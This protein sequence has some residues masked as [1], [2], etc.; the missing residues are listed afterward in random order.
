[1]VRFQPNRCLEVLR[2]E[3]SQIPL[4]HGVSREALKIKVGAAVEPTGA[5][6][7]WDFDG[8]LNE[9]SDLYCER[10]GVLFYRN[11]R[12]VVQKVSARLP[13]EG[14][15]KA[16]LLRYLRNECGDSSSPP[17][18]RVEVWIERHFKDIL[19]V[20]RLR[21][22]DQWV[23]TSKSSAVGT[24]LEVER[25]FSIQLKLKYRDSFALFVDGSSVT[26]E[27]VATH[28]ANALKGAPAAVTVYRGAADPPHGVHD[29]VVDDC[30]GVEYFICAGIAE[31]VA[32]GRSTG[33]VCLC[34]D[35]RK[36]TQLC[37]EA[38]GDSVVDVVQLSK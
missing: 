13:A 38:F 17:T 34:R 21:E 27:D 15:T 36:V 4:L 25:S 22:V 16:Q 26:K 7:E 1:M 23:F 24:S 12:S 5:A 35:K 20:R 11:W 14:V 18:D 30:V 3:L 9:A 33:I 19:C 6:T 29:V 31:V 10:D 28:L 32:S 37:A 8:A 2:A